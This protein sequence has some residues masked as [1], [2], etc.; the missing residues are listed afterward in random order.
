MDIIDKL[1]EKGSIGQKTTSN[2]FVAQPMEGNCGNTNGAV[3]ELTINK[4]KKIAE[5][6]WG[7]IIVEAIS[8]TPYSLARKHALIMNREN[9]DGFKRLVDQVKSI[10]PDAI[11][12]F[13]ITHSGSISNPAFSEQ[14]AVSPLSEGRLLSSDEIEKVKESFVECALMAEEAGADGIDYKSCH[15]YLGAEI[16]RPMNIR[17]DKWG[18]S[19]ENRT[20]FLRE[21]ITELIARRKNN[22]FILG[23]RISMYEGMRGCT[24]TNSPD[25]LIEDLTEQ[26]KLLL[27]M[28]SLGMDYVN[29]SAGIPA[30]TPVLTR[31]VQRAELMYLHHLRYT[32]LAKEILRTSDMKVIGSAYSIL[33]ERAFPV[34]EEMLGKGY[35]DFI[36]W[37][38]QTLA[39]PLLPK[40]IKNGEVPDYCQACSGCSKMMVKQINVG[41]IMFDEYYKNYWKQ[42]L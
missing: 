16:L 4:Y 14:V 29:V 36:G 20:R 24:G 41:C 35:A 37:G 32:R 39:D 28:D 15:G 25:E 18:G 40:K 27:L 2:R 1:L 30:K 9:L 8:V 10:N 21:G 23:S 3:S 5:G 6:G 19:W 38:R 11:V 26:S 42:N 7:I 17:D 33:R 31:P 13:Q 34:A 22:N 12:I